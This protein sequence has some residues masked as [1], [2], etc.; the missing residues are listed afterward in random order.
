M[1][2]YQARQNKQVLVAG[3]IWIKAIIHKSSIYVLLELPKIFINKLG[4][5]I[6]E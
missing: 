5:G 4:F 1:Y 3:L 2:L 6:H